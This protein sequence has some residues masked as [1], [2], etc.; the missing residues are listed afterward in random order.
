[1]GISVNFCSLCSGGFCP[2]V[3]HPPEVRTQLGYGSSNSP[4]APPAWRWIRQPLWRYAMQR[5]EIHTG[6][7][8]QW[9]CTLYKPY[10]LSQVARSSMGEQ[11]PFPTF[12][13]GSCFRTNHSYDHFSVQG[14][15]LESPD[16]STGLQAI[17][18]YLY[19]KNEVVYRH[20]TLHGGK[21][22]SY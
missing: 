12:S 6:L 1:M 2:T 13:V 15:F 17:F 5:C 7:L 18:N 20:E 14:S 3:V 4:R 16:N 9:S 22:C 10:F 21:L 11:Q 19:L 8:Y